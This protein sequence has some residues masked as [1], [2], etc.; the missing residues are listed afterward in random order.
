MNVHHLTEYAARSKVSHPR[1]VYLREDKLTA[2]LDQWLARLFRPD[3]LPQTIDSLARAQD[4]GVP[5]ALS[6]HA[7]REI[8]ACDAKLRQH[9]AALEAGAEPQI[10]AAWMT[11]TQARRS[12]AESRLRL[13]AQRQ[14][15]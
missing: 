9:R 14:P 8:A 3:C 7:R 15:R 2:H 10:V 6:E 12:G 1:S 5:A 4:E 11:E 13:G